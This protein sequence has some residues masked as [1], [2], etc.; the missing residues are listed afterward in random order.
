M[1]KRTAPALNRSNAPVSVL[2][3]PS[4]KITTTPPLR[5]HCNDVLIAAGSLPS[6]ASGHAPSNFKPVPTTGQRNAA[7]HAR[8]RVGRLIASESQKGS[9]Y[10][11]WFAAT[12]NPPRSGIFSTPEN[13][14]FH[15]MRLKPPTTGRIILSAH[16]G[17]MAV[18]AA[19]R[20]SSL[21]TGAVPLLLT[22]LTVLIAGYLTTA[23]PY[24]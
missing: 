24:L 2:R 8:Y 5:N 4:G 15:N 23:T 13:S 20:G 10:V 11:W 9:M 1:A 7:L 19:A 18:L 16:C 3:A 22:V 21:L 14:I 17:S 6:S 12:I